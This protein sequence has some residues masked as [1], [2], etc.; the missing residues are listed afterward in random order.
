MME[1]LMVDSLVTWAMEYK[2]DAFRFDLMG[3]HVKRNMLAVRDAL[4]ALTLEEDGV[5]GSAIYLYGEGWNF[6]EVADNA[7]GVNATQANMAGTGIGGSQ[8]CFG[9]KVGGSITS[10]WSGY[11][12][13]KV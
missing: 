1:K 6:G 5:D 9:M 11:G 2:V 7:R 12:A 3:H 8:P 10:V 13:K 4:D